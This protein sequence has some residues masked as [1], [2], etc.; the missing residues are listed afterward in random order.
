M[1]LR[2]PKGIVGREVEWDLLREF[3]TSGAAGATLGI[4]WG[5]RRTGKSLLLESLVERTGGFYYEAVRGSSAEALRELGARLGAHQQAAAPLSLDTWD[6]AIGALLKL[7]QKHEIPIVLDEYPYLLEHTPELDSIIQRAFGPRNRLRTSS[8]ARL[9][10]CGSAVTIMRQILSGS[11]PLHGRAGLDLRISPFDFRVARELHGLD[12][13]NAAVRTF[14]VIGGVAAYAREMVGGDLPANIGDFDRWVCRRVL[15]PASP[16]FNEVGLLLS[17]DAATSKARKINLYHAALAGV[18]SGHH[19]HKSLTGYVRIPG[20]SLSPIVDA[21]TSAEF[22]ER[23]QDPVRD[24]RPTYYPAD[25]LIRFHY[26]VIRRHGARLA[27]HDANTKQ[28][29]RQIKSTFE[30]Q[31]LGPCFE[32]M[33]RYWCQHFA[34]P[35]TL[36]GH[37]DYVGPTVVASAESAE[38]ELD[39]VVAEANA[40]A[41][42]D[43][44]ILAIGEAKAG[45]RIS[46]RHLRRLEVARSLLGPRARDAK[47]LLFAAA[48]T[49]DLVAVGAQRTDVELVD[50]ERL[51]GGA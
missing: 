40:E 47:L 28:I 18:A 42:S 12:D 17:D 3:A 51:Y 50:L 27:R 24:N 49:A 37:P 25:P 35:T 41:A 1:A 38:S 22:L 48:F 14:A 26:A 4:V 19:S 32:A 44:R 34:D 21:L 2:R 6:D 5:R 10:L 9:V 46:A 39:V 8:R 20:A 16:L 13:L 33:A 30:S 29:W 31:A 43:R 15:S 45:E 36:G 7:G 23:I 11:A